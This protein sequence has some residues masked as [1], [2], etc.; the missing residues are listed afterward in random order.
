MRSFSTPLKTLSTLLLIL[1]SCSCALQLLLKE[2]HYLGPRPYSAHKM[3][4]DNQHTTTDN[5]YFNTSEI[6]V[7][8]T[9]S[10]EKAVW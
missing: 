5:F 2:T 6:Y 10:W 7:P 9:E 8:H 3:E 4:K 1:L